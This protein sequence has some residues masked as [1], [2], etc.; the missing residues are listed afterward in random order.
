MNE[1]HILPDRPTRVETI[2]LPNK[3]VQIGLQQV[4]EREI[5]QLD[6]KYEILT[7]VRMYLHSNSMCIPTTICIFQQ[8]MY[9]GGRR[10]FSRMNIANVITL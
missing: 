10:K 4:G 2:R 1:M 9:F 5:V 8:Y 3:L 7:I 6:L